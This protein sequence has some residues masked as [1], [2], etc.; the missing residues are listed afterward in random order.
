MLVHVRRYLVILVEKSFA[1]LSPKYM[2]AYCSEDF[3]CL[4]YKNYK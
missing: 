3:S 2:L 4:K 1:I